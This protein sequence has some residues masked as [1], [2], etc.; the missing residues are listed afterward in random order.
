M[1][2]IQFLEFMGGSNIPQASPNYLI[3]MRFNRISTVLCFDNF[4]H[5]APARPPKIWTSREIWAS[6][7]AKPFEIPKMSVT[8]GQ[9]QQWHFR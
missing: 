4:H 5:W 3:Y 7:W 9:K 6:L 8:V 2:E 1:Q